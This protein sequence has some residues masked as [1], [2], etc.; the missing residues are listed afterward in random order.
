MWAIHASHFV[1]YA[2][3]ADIVKLACGAIAFH[4]VFRDD[5]ETNAFGSFRSSLYPGKNKMYYV[6]REVM[7]AS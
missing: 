6:L 4:P 2:S 3:P 1:F 7:L 5:E